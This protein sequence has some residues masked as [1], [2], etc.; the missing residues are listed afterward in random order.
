ME[1]KEW[2][3]M[4]KVE[5]KHVFARR[6]LSIYSHVAKIFF[7]HIT[8]LHTFLMKENFISV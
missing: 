3:T 1:R 6:H 4:V 8:F 5:T 7:V 2:E